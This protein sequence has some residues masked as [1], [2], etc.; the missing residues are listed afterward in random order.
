MKKTSKKFQKIRDIFEE[1]GEI[2]DRRNSEHK[3]PYLFLSIQKD[4]EDEV[5]K[6]AVNG[7]RGDF[8]KMIIKAMENDQ[9]F[10]SDVIRASQK[11]QFDRAT[12]SVKSLA[13]AIGKLSQKKSKI[14]PSGGFNSGIDEKKSESKC[15]EINP[16]LRD[17]CKP[18]PITDFGIKHHIIILDEANL[19][20][21]KKGNELIELR[22]KR[23]EIETEL[24]DLKVTMKK[25]NR[26]LYSLANRIANLECNL[27]E[28]NQSIILKER[29]DAKN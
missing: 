11:F 16:V 15:K 3:E 1:I 14:Y 2:N 9:I 6:G 12:K 28:I 18:I 21:S 5:L 26:D 4:G 22:K 25:D 17:F 19:I 24:S 29:S 8:E 10:A 27:S 13:E 20:L 7:E 23:L